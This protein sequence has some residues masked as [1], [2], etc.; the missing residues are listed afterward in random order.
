MTIQK[1][2]GAITAL[3]TPF[4][5]GALDEAAFG[6]LVESQIAQGIHGLVPCGTTGESPTLTDAEHRRVIALCIEAA[7]G[8]VPVIAGCGSNDTAYAIALTQEAQAMG[9]DAAL[10]VTPYY[11][12]PT[13][14]GLYRHFE[15]IHEATDI[16]IILYNIPGRSVVNIGPQTMARLSHL[17]RVIGVKDATGDIVRPARTRADCGA[18]F[19]QL[20]GDDASTL[21]FMAQG[22]HGAISVTSNLAPALCARM[23]EAWDRG[24]IKTAQAINDRLMPLNDA[25]FCETS[26]G[27]VKYAAHLLGL[28]AYELRL[29]M[30]PIA[31][32]S[33]RMV[34]SAL[35]KSGLL[36]SG[37]NLRACAS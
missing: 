15:A 20:S 26:P 35:E 2:H 7:R 34:E 11:N 1:F 17:P 32:E 5:A 9:A 30:V 25:L 22:G 36:D 16:P 10:H 14:E 4:R 33:E 31:K 19:I 37:P 18:D 24:D 8:R 23:A 21:A 12:K 3:I 28:C 6:D 29:P 27:P 13:Q